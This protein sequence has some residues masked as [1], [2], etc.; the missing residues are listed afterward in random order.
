MSLYLTYYKRT[1]LTIPA[2]SSLCHHR[3]HFTKEKI[4]KQVLKNYILFLS[5]SEK[6][7]KP[8]DPF[9]KT[10]FQRIWKNRWFRNEPSL[11][12]MTRQQSIHYRKTL[13]Q[14]KYK[15]VD[16]PFVRRSVKNNF[17]SLKNWKLQKIVERGKIIFSSLCSTFLTCKTFCIL[18]CNL[19]R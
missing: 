17:F 15:F 14:K 5:V 12:L 18:F 6:K 10:R 1:S 9:F 13:S 8:P 11:E 7:K 4:S 16:L 19:L 2:I 3:H